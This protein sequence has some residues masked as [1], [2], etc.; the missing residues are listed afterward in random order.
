MRATLFSILNL[1]NLL[2]IFE[3]LALVVEARRSDT[4]S[5]S[6][7][8]GPRFVRSQHG[9]EPAVTRDEP[10]RPDPVRLV[11]VHFGA[12]S[13]AERAPRECGAEPLRFTALVI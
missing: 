9:E 12:R 13:A 4:A 3:Y 5:C 6:P 8:A 2:I 1:L 7:L 11:R 10:R